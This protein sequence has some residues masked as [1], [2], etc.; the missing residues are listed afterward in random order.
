MRRRDVD[1]RTMKTLS[2]SQAGETKAA[3]DAVSLSAWRPLTELSAMF[4]VAMFGFA[5]SRIKRVIIA[6]TT[7]HE[8]DVISILV[9]GDDGSIVFVESQKNKVEWVLCRREKSASRC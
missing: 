2:I 6:W 8:P 5:T 4:F 7:Q 1:R 3:A 9:S